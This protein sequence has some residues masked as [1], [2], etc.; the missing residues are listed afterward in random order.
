[1]FFGIYIFDLNRRNYDAGVTFPIAES[2]PE[3][4]RH[5][6]TSSGNNKTITARRHLNLKHFYK[7][8]FQGDSDFWG[9]LYNSPNICSDLVN[10]DDIVP[11]I[12]FNS[13]S[14]SLGLDFTTD[15]VITYYVQFF[16]FWASN[17]SKMGPVGIEQ[18][19]S[20]PLFPT[21]DN[22]ADDFVSECEQITDTL[23][24]KAESRLSSLSKSKTSFRAGSSVSQRITGPQGLGVE[25]SWQERPQPTVQTRQDLVPVRGCVKKTVVTTQN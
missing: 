3:A 17:V 25:R 12:G 14:G 23:E 6:L 1:M 18:I 2:L 15:R 21:R 5:L 16:N 4:K 7:A 10:K 11:A 13:A 22:E 19:D 24:A 9:D 8:G 20:K